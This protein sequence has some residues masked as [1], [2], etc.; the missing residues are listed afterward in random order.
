MSDL[1][2]KDFTE[3]VSADLDVVLEEIKDIDAIS[4]AIISIIT[5]IRN[6]AENYTK[7]EVDRQAI[8][9]EVKLKYPT[10]ELFTVPTAYSGIYVITPQNM[11]NVKRVAKLTSDFTK[12]EL[13]RHGGYTELMKTDEGKRKLQDID[14]DAGDINN[15]YILEDCVLYPFNFKELLKENEVK[16][17]LYML[18]LDKIS[19]ISEWVDV[20]VEKV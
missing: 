15:Q 6:S 20:V 9:A 14:R 11:N 18:L 13:E 4:T 17:G 16:S 2:F 10:A 8:I 7:S 5:D 1:I 12:A 19:D 3:R